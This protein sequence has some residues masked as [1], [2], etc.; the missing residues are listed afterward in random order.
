MLIRI[1][2]A[3]L[4]LMLPTACDGGGGSSPADDAT[5]G[6][7]LLEADTTPAE[8]ADTTPIAE[9]TAV[10]DTAP[11]APPYPAGP[12]GTLQFDTIDPE[13]GFYDPWSGIT[14][15]VSEV[16]NDPAVKVLVINSGAGWC[17]PCRAEAWDMVEVYEKYHDDGLAVM[18][19]LFEDALGDRLW[20]DEKGIDD[21][22][23]FMNLWR[24]NLGVSIGQEKRVAN[25]PTLVDI[26]YQLEPYYNGSPYIPVTVVVRTRDM[27]I[28]ATDTGYDPGTLDFRIKSI[29]Y[30]HDTQ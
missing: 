24:D 9:D 10:A 12:Y 23:T 5:S 22:F 20:D 19:A 3:A 2:I 25:Y 28:V 6:A 21:D 30:A 16:W 15:K 1:A 8:E 14:H 17:G 7:D 29:L 13:L 27:K 11:E 4:F 26:G 18:Y